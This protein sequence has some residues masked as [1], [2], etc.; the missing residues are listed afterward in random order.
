MSKM[1]CDWGAIAGIVAAAY[2]VGWLAV[3]AATAPSAPSAPDYASMSY[4]R[5]K[6]V[7]LC[8]NAGSCLAP[9]YN[10]QM[11]RDAYARA[12]KKH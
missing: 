8:R 11:I 6:S 2:I 1:K 5:F 4:E 3:V 12:T 9:A 10:E 7:W